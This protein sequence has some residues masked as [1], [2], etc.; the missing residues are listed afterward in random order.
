MSTKSGDQA[1][2]F[3]GGA[4]FSGAAG[5]LRTE[6]SQ[7]HTYVYADTNGDKQA[8]FALDLFGVRQLTQDRLQ[9]LSRRRASV[10]RHQASRPQRFDPF[11]DEAGGCEA[12]GV[13]GQAQPHARVVRAGLDGLVGAKP[14]VPG[15]HLGNNAWG[16][17][18]GSRPGP[19]GRQ[20]PL[21]DVCAT[22][23]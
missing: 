4:A 11:E 14:H 22:C 15:V 12:A 18:A 16:G 7:G 2:K 19:P 23:R 10:G 5:E 13:S 17:G 6:V 1:F 20:R 9:S 3:V 8:D 21:R